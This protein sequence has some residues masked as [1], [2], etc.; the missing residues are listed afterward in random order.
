ML[1]SGF[2]HP[3]GACI[4]NG[5]DAA[6]LGIEEI[7]FAHRVSSLVGSMKMPAVVGSEEGAVYK[8]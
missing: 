2:Y 5:G 4:D 8:L 6:G 3:T 1:S 7:G